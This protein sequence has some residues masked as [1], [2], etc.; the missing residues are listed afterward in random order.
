MTYIL[1][2]VMDKSLGKHIEEMRGLGEVL[3]KYNFPKAPSEWEDDLNVLKMRELIIDGYYVLA[4]YSKADY[5]DHFLETLQ[6]L[7]KNCPFLPFFLVCKL[8]KRF[9][10]ER[11]LSL[12]EFV[13]DNRKIY[14]W[15]LT[16]DME[17]NPIPSPFDPE[18]KRCVYEGLEYGYMQPSQVNF[19]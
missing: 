14:C 18:V 5:G 19:H 9:L 15:T 16:L 11:E 1:W 17:N 8:A 2:G 7:G 12:L 10:G 3:V 6:V 4:H 13:R